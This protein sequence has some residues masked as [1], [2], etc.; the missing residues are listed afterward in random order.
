MT[1]T[2]TEVGKTWWARATLDLLRSRGV[3][4]AARKPAQSYDPG[5]LGQTDAEILGRASGEPAEV[6]CP[7]HRWYPVPMAP[8]MAAAVL[9]L[10]AFTIGELVTEMA[11]AAA[12]HAAVRFVEGAG[13]PRSPLAA[14]GD[15]VSLGRAL[16][17]DVVVLV[18]PAGLGAINAVRLSAAPFHTDHPDARVVV[19]LNH[20]DAEDELHRRNHGWLADEGFH[21]VTSPAEL[22]EALT[23]GTASHR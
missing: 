2:A 18:A 3:A 15:T 5:E 1:G 7:R 13:G 17:A 6:V 16:D 19:G 4:V 20:Y 10:P 22:A 12:G 23:T 11:P 21:L 14:D 8:P 9:G